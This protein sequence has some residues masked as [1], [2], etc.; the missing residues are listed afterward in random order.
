MCHITMRGTNII[1]GEEQLT[2]FQFLELPFLI[3][4][5]TPAVLC[6]VHRSLMVGHWLCETE[7]AMAHD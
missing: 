3:S 5:L 4:M 1:Q 2:S 7:G 6:P